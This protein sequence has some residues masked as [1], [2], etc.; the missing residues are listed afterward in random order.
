MASGMSLLLATSFLGL[1][2][3]LR[4]RRLKCLEMAAA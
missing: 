1:R 3:Y 4:Q 2:R